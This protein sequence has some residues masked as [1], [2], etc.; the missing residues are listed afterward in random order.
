MLSTTRTT[1]HFACVF[2]RPRSL[3]AHVALDLYNSQFRIPL[4]DQDVNDPI[5]IRRGI[6]DSLSDRSQRRTH[7]PMD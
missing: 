6:I 4:F 2:S 5:E 3:E 7:A 1:K